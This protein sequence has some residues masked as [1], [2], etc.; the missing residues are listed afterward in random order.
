VRTLI[1]LYALALGVRLALVAVFAEPAYPDSYYYVDVARELARSGRLETDFVWIFAEVGGRLPTD[2]TL[3]IPSNAHWMPLASFVQVP[4][5]AVLGPSPLASALP[6]ALIGSLAAPLAWLIAR[7]AGARPLVANAAGILTALPALSLVYMTQPDNFSLFQ[8]LVAGALW[9]TARGLKGHAGSFAL[10][11]LLAGL[12]MLSRN[13][14]AIVAAVIGLAFLWDR[15]RAWRSGGTRVPRIP[16]AA[17]V[18]AAALF[19]VVMTP[20]LARQWLTFGSLSPS[21]ASGKVLYLR[22]IAEWNSITTP[23]TLDYFLGQGAGALVASRVGGLVAAVSI[24]ATLVAGI[25]LAPFMLVGAWLRR[26]SVDFGPFFTYAVLLFAFSAIVSAVHVPGGTFIHSAVALAPHSYVLA[27]EG[28]LAATAWVAARRPR[29]DARQAGRLF[30]IAAVGFSVLVAVAG[31]VF[32]L[33][34]Y[35][36]E[37]DQRQ[38]V[39][40]ALDAGAAERPRDV[41]RCRRLPLPHRPRRGRPRERPDRDRRGGRSGLRDP[42]ARRR[43]RRRRR[44][45][46]ARAGRRPSR[47]DR[48]PDPRDRRARWRPSGRGGLPGLPRERRHAMHAVLRGRRHD[49]DR[50]VTRRELVLTGGTVFLVALAVRAVAAWVIPFPR[51]EDTAY[52]V[53]VARN[54]LEGRGLVSDAL[55]SFGTPPLVFPRPAFE[56]WLPLP[57]FL[58]AVPMAVLGHTFRAAQVSAVLVGALVPL[59]AWRLALDVAEE[60]GL[61]IS[62]ARVFALGVGLTSAVYLPL[63]LHSALPDSTMPFASLTLGA[64]LV[65]ARILRRGAA[66]RPTDRRVLLLGVLLGLAAWTRNEAVWLAATW[67][68]LAW[69]RLPLPRAGRAAVIGATAIVSIA[70]FAPWLARNLAEFGTPLPGQ[71]L[72]NALSLEGRDI[73]AWTEEPTLQRYLAAG[74]GE[75]LRLRVGGLLH[76]LLNVL[77]YLGVPISL[78]GLLALPWQ[79]RGAALRPLLVFGVLTFLV[80]SLLFP[81]ATTWGTFLHAAGAVHV[82][83]I[84][85][86]LLMLDAAIVR[87]GRWRGWT[88]PVAWLGPALTVFGGA[89]FSLVLL[90]GFG[91]GSRAAAVHY[92]TLEARLAEIGEPLRKD[93][94]VISNFPIWIAE[95]ARVPSLALPDEAPEAVL[96]LARTFPGTRLVVVQGDDHRHWPHDLDAGA[97]GAD[98][99]REVEV[100]NPGSSPDPL[101]DTR[102]FEVVCE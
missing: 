46:R 78:I 59:L 18:G 39:A 75:L 99:F 49:E 71:A 87:I 17:A 52:Y 16:V 9:L 60:R 10:A 91:A 41:D 66:T 70:V 19:L 21:T 65:M 22:S 84:I 77:L 6:F 56:V 8:P 101:A 94:P 62:R 23:A 27:I 80:T 38:E 73:F 34:R 12:A 5:I 45:G 14:G 85:S 44:G 55:W 57:T 48:R 51:P 68:L 79:G 50:R 81:V 43:A 88:R 26:R 61:P 96:D 92:E 67:A 1:L 37:R 89:L 4:F 72:T 30:V 11:G 33:G 83:L 98:C 24:Y 63:V 100:A 95:T 32:V 82:L 29:W 28:I 58:A 13:D 15:W 93:E 74:P 47:L 42:L 69:T 35:A 25:L 102:V 90:P 64:C 54:L 53:G 86:C 97:P 40:R 2:P 7:E 3:P 31:A 76:N 20:W 36:R